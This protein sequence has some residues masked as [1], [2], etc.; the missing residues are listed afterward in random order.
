M[1]ET[2]L[3]H[4][5]L[6][7][8]ILNWI[9]N[10]FMNVLTPEKSI[11]T[12]FEPHSRWYR[13]HICFLYIVFCVSLISWLFL[14]LNGSGWKVQRYAQSASHCFVDCPL[15][16]NTGI[17]A[18]QHELYQQAISYCLS[19]VHIMWRNADVTQCTYCLCMV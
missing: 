7:G 12:W 16:E 3:M 8:V 9:T 19:T 17:M 14:L 2:Q 18:L 6:L 1:N 11:C 15:I 10:C 5:L 13:L 4:K